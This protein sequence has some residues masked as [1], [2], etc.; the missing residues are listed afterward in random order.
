ME[1]QGK[2]KKSSESRETKDTIAVVGVDSNHHA[3]DGTFIVQDIEDSRPI[4]GTQESM[5]SQEQ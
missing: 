5:N 2:R 3:V 1:V 4:L